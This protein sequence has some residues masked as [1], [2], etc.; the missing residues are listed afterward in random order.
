MGIHSVHLPGRDAKCLPLF[1]LSGQEED[2]DC[3]KS[4]KIKKD[5]HKEE[6][7]MDNEHLLTP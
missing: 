3:T 1:S 5:A 2:T 6:R 7:L 4:S